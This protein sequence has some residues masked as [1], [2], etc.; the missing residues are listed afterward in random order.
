M[1]VRYSIPHIFLI[2]ILMAVASGVFG[3][4]DLEAMLESGAA[5][6]TEDISSG[7]F[8]G[9][10]LI[11]GHTVELRKEGALE[12]IISHRFGTLNSGIDNLYGL[13]NANM[14]M[15]LDYSITDRL[16]IGVGRS[17]F[18]KVLDGFV[19][20]K[21]LAQRRG[22]NPLPFSL[23]YYGAMSVNTLPWPGGGL[24]Y[25]S[26]HR[27]A[28]A[29]Q[30]LIASK[31]TAGTSLQVMPAV[32]HRNLVAETREENLIYALGVGGRQRLTGSLAMTTEYYYQ[33]NNH[34]SRNYYN[35]FSVGFDIETGGHVFQLHFTNSNP[36]H[37]RGYITET[38]GDFFGGDVH[39]GFNITR[40][41]Q[42][43]RAH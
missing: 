37:D 4:D 6:E 27:Y 35:S 12:L 7:T 9:T 30:V 19:K 25:A 40:T 2:A 34:S 28:Y 11:N 18:Q 32:V 39:F 8:K 23:V 33:F 21:V 15:G 20:Y 22:A 10:R 24:P 38:T 41:F 16:T 3:Q 13:D 17:S 1:N 43:K 42:V 31:L 36:T 5:G 14:R 29:H 26:S